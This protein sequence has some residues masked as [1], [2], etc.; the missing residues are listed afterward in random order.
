[1]SFGS[2]SANAIRA[3]NQGARLGG[4]Y[5]DTGEGPDLRSRGCIIRASGL[6]PSCAGS[7]V[8]AGAQR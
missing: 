7:E 2:L 1:M 8:G 4:F 6:S 3:L 5:H